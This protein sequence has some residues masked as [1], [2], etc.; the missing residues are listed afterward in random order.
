M[1]PAAVFA[2][3]GFHG[4]STQDIANRLGI[5]QAAL[6]YYFPSKEAALEESATTAS[7]MQ[8]SASGR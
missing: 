1:Q 4:A 5:N 7:R 2:E 6:Y 3:K 8:W